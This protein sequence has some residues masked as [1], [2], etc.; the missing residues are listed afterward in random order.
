MI[1]FKKDNSIFNSTAHYLVNPVNSKGVSGAGL[2]LEF[3]NRFPQNYKGYH[4]FCTV[5]SPKGGD[6]FW[7]IPSEKELVEGDR[8]IIN[9]ATK[10]DWRKPS[11]LE[12]I[13]KGLD[14]LSQQLEEIYPEKQYPVPL[15]AFPMLGC[16]KGKLNTQ[17]VLSIFSKI[18]FDRQYDIEVY[19]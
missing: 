15:V 8:R 17:D 7:Y 4:N 1:I 9:F 19:L 6:L 16:G 2:A 13:E 3:K 18:F 11:K 10:E 14:K 5:T 12:W